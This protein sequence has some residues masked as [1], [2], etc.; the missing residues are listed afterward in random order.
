MWK[1]HCPYC[2]HSAQD[3]WR[4]TKNIS[5]AGTSIS[6]PL[7]TSP[8]DLS[9]TSIHSWSFS[10]TKTPFFFSLQGLQISL[11]ET[12]WCDQIRDLRRST[13]RGPRHMLR[14]LPKTFTNMHISLQWLRFNSVTF[15]RLWSQSQMKLMSVTLK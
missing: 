14:I 5:D 2:S 1:I 9:R 13:K 7:I 4:P 3:W 6:E 10:R 15:M 11:L 8:W 12:W